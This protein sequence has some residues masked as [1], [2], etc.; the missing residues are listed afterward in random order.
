MA[1][2]YHL[3]HLFCFPGNTQS[4]KFYYLMMKLLSYEVRYAAKQIS[5]RYTKQERKNECK[6]IIC[7]YFY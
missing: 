5:L 3:F 1:E 2:P 6:R 4:G 7:Y